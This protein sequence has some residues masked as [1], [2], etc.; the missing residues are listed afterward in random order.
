MLVH[1]I[2]GDIVIIKLIFALK[3][4]SYL[5]F[6]CNSSPSYSIHN[7]MLSFLAEI[8]KKRFEVPPGWEKFSAEQVWTLSS[9]KTPYADASYFG[10]SRIKN[11]FKLCIVLPHVGDSSMTLFKDWICSKFGLQKPDS[12][13]VRILHHFEII[14]LCIKL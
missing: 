1:L 6:I 8:L 10:S 3:I 9:F 4:L 2:L 13:K 5:I 11:Y 12:S 7:Y 14:I